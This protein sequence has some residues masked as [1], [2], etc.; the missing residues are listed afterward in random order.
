[1]DLSIV[2]I[3]WNTRDLLRDCLRSVY[4]TVRDLAFEI[5]VVDNGSSDGSAAMLRESFPAVR[6]VENHENRGF[7]AANNQAFRIMDGRYAL[8]L[9]TD[10]VLTEG[11]VE[12]LFRFMEGHSD[13]AMACGQLLNRDGSLQNSIA[14]FPSLLTLA[15]NMPLLEILFPRR[16]PS[17]RYRHAEP[18]QVDSGVGA[19]L[20]V[21]RDAMDDAGLLDERYFFYFEETDWAYAMSRKG[22]KVFHVPAAR[23]YHL[24]GQSV[25]T[26]IASRMA[27][28]RSR[29]A[30]FRKWFGRPYYFTVCCMLFVRLAVNAFLSTAG[31][32]LTLGQHAELRRKADVYQEL[33]AW[34]LRGLP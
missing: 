9:N 18:V 20:L 19:C 5:I 25:G 26:G 34:H 31:M 27:F 33:L 14:A 17:K 15:A 2:I 28:Y 10:A 11:A 3:N 29:Y 8:L 24:Q 23:I 16:F 22:W 12:A 32:L 6:I 30:F 13:A 7:A 1:M 4:G 21:R